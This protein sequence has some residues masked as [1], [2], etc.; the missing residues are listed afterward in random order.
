[1]AKVKKWQEAEDSMI[2]RIFSVRYT[3]Q[4]AAA[5]GTQLRKLL[6]YSIRKNK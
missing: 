4:C 3:E 2:K 5:T 1:M 6:I